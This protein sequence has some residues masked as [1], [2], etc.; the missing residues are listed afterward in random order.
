MISRTSRYRYRTAAICMVLTM[1]SSLA[2]AQATTRSPSLHVSALTMLSAF[3]AD[4]AR[5]AWFVKTA[6]CISWSGADSA[7]YRQQVTYSFGPLIVDA[8]WN[9]RCIRGDTSRPDDLR[10][11][12][13]PLTAL[14]PIGGGSPVVGPGHFWI[15]PGALKVERARDGYPESTFVA[16]AVIM[17]SPVTVRMWNA[18]MD[19]PATGPNCSRDDCAA[20]PQSLAD[21]REFLRRVRLW[22]RTDALRLTTHDD[23]ALV[24]RTWPT[25]T[26]PASGSRDASREEPTALPPLG[27]LRAPVNDGEL[28]AEEGISAARI[29]PRAIRVDRCGDLATPATVRAAPKPIVMTRPVN[30]CLGS[31]SILRYEVFRLAISLPLVPG[32]RTRSDPPRW[33]LDSPDSAT[34]AMWRTVRPHPADGDFDQ[35]ADF[36]DACPGTPPGREVA[37][38]G[39]SSPCSE[40]FSREV[41]RAASRQ[42]RSGSSRT[43]RDSAAQEG[44]RTKPCGPSASGRNP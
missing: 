38:N 1:V 25:H 31:D 35:V 14:V 32:V 20:H 22:Y 15:V 37:S 18:F 26:E 27:F 7:T 3:G 19:R 44:R 4:P 39:C 17:R 16:P 36:E 43:R 24:D 23:W 33:R 11:A 21:V 34:L 9:R 8:L 2:R 40:A 10:V 29:D 6:K 13:G 12:V 41:A 42:N 28:R 5:V 30:R